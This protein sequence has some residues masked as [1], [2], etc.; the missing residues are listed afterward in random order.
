MK[1]KLLFVIILFIF[2]GSYLPKGEND[3]RIAWQ[4]FD[5]GL[6][7]SKKMKKKM[8]VDVYTNWCGWCKKMESTTYSDA[9]VSEY[10][11]SKYVAVKLN[12]ESKDRL[13]YMDKSFS[14]AELSRGFGVT[15]YPATIFLDEYQK[16]ITVVPGYIDAKEFM[17]ILK[18]IYE[19][20]YKTKT[21]SA[22]RESTK[23]D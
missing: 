4:N 10:I 18:F 14:E 3:S 21:Y 7:T 20:I 12:A 8:I 6:S 5:T 2:I 16:P 22:Y 1:K 19:D 13:T 11:K 17:Y 9:R 15:G 23:I